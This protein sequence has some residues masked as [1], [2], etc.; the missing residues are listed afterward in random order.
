MVFQQKLQPSA[1][2]GLSTGQWQEREAASDVVEHWADKQ[3]V[4]V[5][6]KCNKKACIHTHMNTHNHPPTQTIGV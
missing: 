1:G 3:K 6:A 4:H 5:Y 2:P